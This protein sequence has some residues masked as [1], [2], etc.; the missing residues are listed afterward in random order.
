M[1]EGKRKVLDKID[2][3]IDKNGMMIINFMGLLLA[4]PPT[5]SR[6]SP[7]DHMQATPRRRLV[8]I[9]RHGV[10]PLPRRTR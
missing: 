10:E 9:R 2:I 4:T 1:K 5:G 6:P 7:F 8:P 3:P